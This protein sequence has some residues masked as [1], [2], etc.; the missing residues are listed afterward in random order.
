MNLKWLIAASIL[1]VAAT[2][3]IPSQAAPS[4]GLRDFAPAA[5]QSS[6]VEQTHYRRYRKYRHYRHRHYGYRPGV[7]FYLGHRHRHYHR[8]HRHW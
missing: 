8:W 2:M 7:Y 3:S 6:G 1:I 5:R 4:S